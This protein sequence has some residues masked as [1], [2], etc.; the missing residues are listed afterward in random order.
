MEY[1]YFINSRFAF[2]RGVYTRNNNLNSRGCSPSDFLSLSSRLLLPSKF[3]KLPRSWIQ[4]LSRVW[5]H[6][7]K[8]RLTTSNMKLRKCYDEDTHLQVIFS[9][10]ISNVIGMC[11]EWQFIIYER[12]PVSIMGL[13][14]FLSYLC[15]DFTVPQGHHVDIAVYVSRRQRRRPI[16]IFLFYSYYIWT[17]N[18][19]KSQ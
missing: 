16:Y 7:G 1:C 13:T 19:E 15:V 14:S 9:S 8:T 4:L 18:A 10:N 2:Y 17:S 3:Y 12:K 11:V 6:R 5:K